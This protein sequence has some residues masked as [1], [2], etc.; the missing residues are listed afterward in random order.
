M[1]MS[2]EGIEASHNSCML[3]EPCDSVTA[4]LKL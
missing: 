1:I 4:Y 3:R 2:Q